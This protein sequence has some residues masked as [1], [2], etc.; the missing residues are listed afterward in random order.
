MKLY[1]TEISPRS[2]L[3]LNAYIAIE[4]SLEEFYKTLTTENNTENIIQKLYHYI[5]LNVL[6]KYIEYS[7]DRN[8][9]SEKFW[10]L[11]IPNI[12]CIYEMIINENT[13]CMKV[14]KVSEKSLREIK[15]S[16][17]LALFNL[18]SS[19]QEIR[20]MVFLLPENYH[21]AS[22]QAFSTYFSVYSK[23]FSL[24]G[25]VLTRGS[26]NISLCPKDTLWEVRNPLRSTNKPGYFEKT[27]KKTIKTGFIPTAY[28]YIVN[29]QDAHIESPSLLNLDISSSYIQ[30]PKDR[31]CLKTNCHSQMTINQKIFK[32]LKNEEQLNYYKTRTPIRTAEIR[33]AYI[34][35]VAEETKQKQSEN[36]PKPAIENKKVQMPPKLNLT[37]V[38]QKGPPKLLIKTAKTNPFIT[39]SALNNTETKN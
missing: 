21:I 37:G 20:L 14:A 9:S 19:H 38:N 31:N 4:N 17:D 5:S 28:F 25:I 35:E 27:L 22:L 2:N 23:N 8:R 11:S 18:I 32:A 29:A 10:E 13:F 30:K 3:D 26:V 24:S 36:A 16:S 12:L 6:K 33:N 39:E 1:Q 34:A 15:T 7:E